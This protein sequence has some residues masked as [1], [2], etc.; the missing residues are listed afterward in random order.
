MTRGSDP[1][2]D[3]ELRDLGRALPWQRPDNDARELA[4]ARLIAVA[5][6]RGAPV[7][8]PMVP[9]ALA[10]AAIATAA[11]AAIALY[12]LRSGARDEHGDAA[13]VAV[14]LPP[15]AAV[16]ATGSAD[17]DHTATRGADGAVDEVVRLRAGRVRVLARGAAD[18]VRVAASDGE[19]D[20]RGA[21]EIAVADGALRE[22]SV[23]RGTAVVRP[24]GQQAVFLAAGQTWR[25]PV[26]TAQLDLADA[27]VAPAMVAAT[28]SAPAM[29]APTASAPAMVAPTAN[30]SA[31]IAPAPVIAAARPRVATPAPA[32]EV[33]PV[34]P[35][36]T[37]LAPSVTP[38]ART[39][40]PPAAIAAARPAPPAADLPG[41]APIAPAPIAPTP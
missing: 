33:T 29:V 35:S 4:R 30:A 16:T 8:R 26:V 15:E 32:P 40:T 25:A 22:V 1:L 28:A 39:E 38:L 10:L 41:P 14:A 37:P 21:F 23:E 19:V 7:A 34:A 20:G 9:R 12:A 17:F 18:H 5:A 36:V 2:R 24:R 27:Q 11:A 31:R 6:E 13:G 3:D